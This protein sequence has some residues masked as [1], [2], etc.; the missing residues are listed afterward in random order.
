MCSGNSGRRAHHA[1]EQAKREAG[2]AAAAAAQ[3]QEQAYKEMLAMIPEAPKK[4]DYT[5]PPMS[6]RSSLDDNSGVRTAKSKRKSTLN[7]NKGIAALRIPLNTG[8]SKGS[9]INVG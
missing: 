8:G 6:T 9:G 4:A 3:R 2:Q 5:P 7:V 1:A